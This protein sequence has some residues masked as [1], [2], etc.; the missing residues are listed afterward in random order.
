MHTTIT[1]RLEQRFAR[2]DSPRRRQQ[3]VA[4]WADIAALAGRTPGDI[5]GLCEQRSIEQNPVVAAL[6]ALHQSGDDDATTVLMT[7]LRPMLLASAGTRCTGHLNDDELDQDWAAVAH[8]LA[9]I[10]PAIEP[11]DSDGQPMVLIAHLGQQIGL[12]R[13]K[14]D[15]AARRWMVR[16]QRN[17]ILGPT[18]PPRDPTTYEFDLQA[19][20]T[21]N[22]SVEDGALARIELDRIAAVVSS[23]QIPRS[24]WDQLVAHRVH[25]LHHN[26][27]DTPGRT[28]VA[29]HRTA[30]RLAWLVDHA[31]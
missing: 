23:G 26:D 3:I 19:G 8:V 1:T 20:S 13:R 31:A 18:I 15:P 25:E 30:T 11:T 24:R 5:I 28:R 10:D 16:R 14:L 6:I 17:L 12:S 7:A 9:T 27:D 4:R 22:S 21:H 29:V 2:C